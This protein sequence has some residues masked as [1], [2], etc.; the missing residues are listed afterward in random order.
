MSKV[1]ASIVNGSMAFTASW[2]DSS[3]AERGGIFGSTIGNPSYTWSDVEQAFSAWIQES[4][5]LERYQRLCTAA[6]E[7]RERAQLATLR[8]KYDE[9]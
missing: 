9:V 5:L 4:G 3:T 7:A 2:N 8:A 1:A 6:I